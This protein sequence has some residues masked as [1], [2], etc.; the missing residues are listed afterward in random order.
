[1]SGDLRPGI[2]HRLDRYTSGVLLV[3]RHDQAH[4]RLAHLRG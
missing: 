3:A 4:R 1:M 2:V